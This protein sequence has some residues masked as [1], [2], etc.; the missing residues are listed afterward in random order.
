MIVVMKSTDNLFTT[1]SDGWQQF[2]RWK[3]SFGYATEK[4]RRIIP[5]MQKK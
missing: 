5:F 3:N 2:A 4:L 1:K